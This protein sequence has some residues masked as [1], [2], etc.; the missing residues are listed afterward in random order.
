MDVFS[1]NSSETA[2]TNLYNSIRV[3]SSFIRSNSNVQAYIEKGG[4]WG[5]I[6]RC[7]LIQYLPGKQFINKLSTRGAAVDGYGIRLQQCWKY[8]IFF[9]GIKIISIY[10]IK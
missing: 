1:T 2:A 7:W 3:N 8:C 10:L 5:N 9:N 4:K 6:I